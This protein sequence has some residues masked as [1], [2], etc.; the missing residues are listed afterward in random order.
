[1]RI[2]VQRL[3]VISLLGALTII[4][5]LTPIGFIQIPFFAAKVTIMHVPVIIGA[6]MEGPLVGAI[7]GLIFGIFSMIQAVIAPTTPLSLLFLNPVIAL[8]P[9]VGIGLAAWGVFRLLQPLRDR[10][11]RMG[12]VVSTVAASVCGTLVNT[13]GVL[14]LMFVIYIKET[15]TALGT[16]PEL[17]G[18]VLLGVAGSNGIMESTAAAVIVTAVMLAMKYRK[19]SRPPEI[20]DSAR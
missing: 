14:G 16:T 7:I 19:K 3:T 9:R 15:A 20:E 10:F 17:V 2:S 18:G 13:I 4:M 1:M 12:F 5:G 8:V 11:D 6:L